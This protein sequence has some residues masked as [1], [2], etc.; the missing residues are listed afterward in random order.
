MPFFTTRPTGSSNI[1]PSL[2]FCYDIVVN[3]HGG[4]LK[5]DS[6]PGQGTRF[7]IILPKE[8]HAS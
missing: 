7:D 1:G 4:E 5:V 6:Q 2:Y 8:R 3:E